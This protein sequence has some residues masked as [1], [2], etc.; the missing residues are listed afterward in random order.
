VLIL[1]AFYMKKIIL[2][3]LIFFPLLALAKPVQP[4]SDSEHE[5][6]CRNTMEIA[7]VIMQ[8]KQNGMPLMKALEANDYAFKKNPDKNMQ[9]IINLITRDAYEQPSYSTPSIKE[10]QLNEFSAKYYLGCMAMYE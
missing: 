5:R 6:N 10:E 7:N 3:G 2:I 1:G 9:K 8:Q 4:V